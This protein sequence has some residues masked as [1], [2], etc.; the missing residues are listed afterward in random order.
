MVSR[1]SEVTPA[2]GKTGRALREL[3]SVRR[4]MRWLWAGVLVLALGELVL[5][6]WIFRVDA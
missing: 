6:L 5:A 2:E 3:Q 1:A 4:R